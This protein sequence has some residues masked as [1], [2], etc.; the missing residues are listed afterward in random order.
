MVRSAYYKH[1]EDTY[2]QEALMGSYQS[3]SV[4]HPIWKK[5]W[6]LKLPGKIKIFIWRCVHNA[7]PCFSVLAN[8]HIGS[9]SQCPICKGGAEDVRHALFLC[10]RARA[11]WE[12]LGVGHTI[13]DATVIDRSGARIINFLLCDT[14]HQ[15]MYSDPIEFSE[16]I[17]PT[18]SYIW[19]Q[20][21]QFV[22]EE[23]VLTPES[24]AMAIHALTLN[25]VRA[26]GKPKNTPRMNQ[27]PVVL[28]G[29]QVLNVDA[30]FHV[31]DHSG[32][33]GAIVRD[34]RGNFI[35]A[36]TANLMHVVDVVSAE[37][38]ALLEG[39]KLLQSLGCS[40]IMVRMDNV[41]VVDALRLNEGQSRVAA[42]VLED[43]RVLLQDFGKV[44]IEHCNRES[45]VVAHELA[46]RGSANIL[47]LWVDA[48]PE[49]IVKFLADDV[50]VIE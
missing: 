30:S 5:I 17:A 18:C 36:S 33:C 45:N 9:I 40:N 38:A 12:A 41:E 4:P 28:S 23:T 13:S 7:I 8:R 37:A 27:W 32:G 22:R 1:W 42:P 20:R 3:G 10:P 19:W 46:S 29:Q 16:L 6:N 39:L 26:A 14:A 49:F 31:G 21:R 15:R 44:T 43:C 2:V 34:S 48:P 11:V 25:F 35:G 24:M 47:S 50:S